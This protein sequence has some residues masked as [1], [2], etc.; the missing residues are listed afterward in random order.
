MTA[1]SR[2]AEVGEGGEGATGRSA[3]DSQEEGGREREGRGRVMRETREGEG[4]EGI[5][6][7]E[8]DEG[9]RGRET[10]EGGRA[11]RRRK[12]ACLSCYVTRSSRDI[13]E[14]SMSCEVSLSS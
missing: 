1:A 10:R 2:R 7:G 6:E 5:R 9:G 13:T 12:E 8:G 3:I 11:R 4:D 14:M